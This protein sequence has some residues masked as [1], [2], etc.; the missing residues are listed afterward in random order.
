[1][2]ITKWISDL[3]RSEADQQE[4]KDTWSYPDYGTVWN[5]KNAASNFW[6]N[7]SNFWQN[8]KESYNT[9]KL[10]RFYNYHNSN[11]RLSMKT[12]ALAIK[13]LI[14]QK[15]NSSVYPL[16]KTRTPFFLK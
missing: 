12:N 3:F 8:A 10:R 4:F 14:P 9:P 5:I 2:W 7:I 15:D 16:T 11:Q 13:K 1:M 6:D